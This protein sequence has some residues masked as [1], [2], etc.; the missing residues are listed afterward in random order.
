MPDACRIYDSLPKGGKVSHFLYI[1]VFTNIS[2]GDSRKSKGLAQSCGPA[3]RLFAL[4]WSRADV[5]GQDRFFLDVA[6]LDEFIGPGGI[7]LKTAQSGAD[8]R[9]VK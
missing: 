6:D 8:F 2:S 1:S 7:S 4:I 9:V 3:F 5:V